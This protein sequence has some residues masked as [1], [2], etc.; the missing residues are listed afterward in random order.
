MINKNKDYMILES[1]QDYDLW[2]N[3]AK[4]LVINNIKESHLCDSWDGQPTNVTAEEHFQHI[5][6]W[7]NNNIKSTIWSCHKKSTKQSFYTSYGAKHSCERD[8]QCYVANNW[9]KLAMIFSGLEVCND[10]RE[11]DN[12]RV[13]YGPVT[14]QSILVNCE[15]FICRRS[16]N[17]EDYNTIKYNCLCEWINT[18]LK[19]STGDWK[20]IGYNKE[21]I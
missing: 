7:C 4:E 15:N 6:D 14:W 5:I 18:D 20:Q 12:G 1:K 8:L 3:K 13:W 19:Y 9:M 21:S 11:D 10:K 17:K 2:L 16:R